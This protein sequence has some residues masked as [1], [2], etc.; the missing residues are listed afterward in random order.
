MLSFLLVFARI[1]LVVM[2]VVISINERLL[3]ALRLQLKE[4]IFP[5][6]GSP[7]LLCQDQVEAFWSLFGLGLSDQQQAN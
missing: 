7:M 1:P 2:Y 3:G 5:D 6:E 4:A